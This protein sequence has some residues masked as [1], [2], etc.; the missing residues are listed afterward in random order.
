MVVHW[1]ILSHC[2]H[3]YLSKSKCSLLLS[4]K[5]KMLSPVY[6][7]VTLNYFFCQSVKYLLI[8]GMTLYHPLKQLGSDHIYTSGCCRVVYS[9][10]NRSMTI[11][12]KPIKMW[13]HPHKARMLMFSNYSGDVV[14]YCVQL[15]TINSTGMDHLELTDTKS[16]SWHWALL[17][18]PQPISSCCA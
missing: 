12:S 2:C 7:W 1:H 11:N 4:V 17:R 8:V 10:A 6:E 15:N 16:L 14:W 18:E 9:H 5:C 13:L 3:D